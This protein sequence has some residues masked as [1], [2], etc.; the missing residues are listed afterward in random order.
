M[1]FS[2]FP[3]NQKWGQAQLTENKNVLC[4]I[5]TVG[6]YVLQ[7][8][9]LSKSDTGSMMVFEGFTLGEIGRGQNE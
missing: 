9:W 1:H 2:I 5:G 6:V 7:T 8:I 4:K 3:E